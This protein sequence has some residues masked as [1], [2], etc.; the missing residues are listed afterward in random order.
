ML[1]T[2]FFLSILGLVGYGFYSWA[3]GGIEPGSK[4]R[5]DTPD[6]RGGGKPEDN[7]K[8]VAPE[9]QEAQQIPQPSGIPAQLARR[10][11][12]PRAPEPLMIADGR[13]GII[14]FVDL[15]SQRPGKIML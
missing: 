11:D 9:I 4:T 7:P 8:K 15:S 6:N 2:L 5:P 1:R 3:T 12:T 10:N 13:I 14:E